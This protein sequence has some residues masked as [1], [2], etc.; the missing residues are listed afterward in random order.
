MSVGAQV[1]GLASRLVS[2]PESGATLPMLVMSMKELPF[3]PAG[4]RTSVLVQG[5]ASD[6]R[7]SRRR[8]RLLADTMRQ[9][10]Y[11][12]I[13]ATAAVW[14]YDYEVVPA[15]AAVYAVGCAKREAKAGRRPLTKHGDR[16]HDFA[17]DHLDSEFTNYTPDVLDVAHACVNVLLFTQATRLDK[18]PHADRHWWA[19]RFRERPY[20]HNYSPA[21]RP[22]GQMRLYR[23]AP[24]GREQ[25]IVW[26][27]Y[28][29]A[30]MG[31]GPVWEATFP[32][33][34]ILAAFPSRPTLDGAPRPGLD[35]AQCYILDPATVD[36]TQIVEV[37]P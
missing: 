29:H 3:V 8:L 12:D 5:L 37:W 24:G 22:D 11:C 20:L 21:A 33:A 23:N 15:T 31:K 2:Q 18:D 7:V 1:D 16:L 6:E 19:D 27:S 30:T 32:A 26:T 13:R 17:H 14:G 35:L 34:A 10:W 25:G 28:A 36:R 9:R 4:T